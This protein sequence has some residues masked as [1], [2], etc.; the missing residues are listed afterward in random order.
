MALTAIERVRRKTG[1]RP[2]LRRESNKGDGVAQHY[3]LKFEPVQ[4]APAPQ[5]WINDILKVETTNYVVNYEQGIISINVPPIENDNLIFQYYSVVYTDAEVQDFL[6]QYSQNVNISAAHILLAWAA[7]IAKLAKRETLQGGGGL[8]AVTRD[9]SVAAK[10][11]RAT[12]KALMD[13]EI[14]YGETLGSQIPAEGLT[15]IPWTE[16]LHYDIVGQKFIR[17]N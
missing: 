17:D 1:D 13:Y 2:A 12:A 8:G 3:K 10:E 11:L 15:E 14:E 5:V 9:T 6:D 7:D 4:A 16:Q